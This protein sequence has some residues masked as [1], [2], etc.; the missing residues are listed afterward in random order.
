MKIISADSHFNEPPKFYDSLHKKYGDIVP[1]IEDEN[2]GSF[3]VSDGFKRPLGVMNQPGARLGKIKNNVSISDTKYIHDLNLRQAIVRKDGVSME[4]L[5]PS[6]AMLHIIRDENIRLQCFIKLNNYLSEL[7]QF[8]KGVLQVPNNPEDAIKII[9]RYNNTRFIMF[10]LYLPNSAY[11][12]GAWDSCFQL[13]QDKNI[14]ICFHAGSLRYKNP[15]QSRIF[16][17]YTHKTSILFFQG[18]ELLNDLL[19]GGV[20]QDYPGLKFIISELGVSWIPYWFHRIKTGLSIYGSLD[21]LNSQNIKK[22]LKRSFYFTTQFDFPTEDTL[23]IIGENNTLFGTDFPHVES[24]HGM[25]IELYEKMKKKHGHAYCS[26]IFYNNF[27]DL[28]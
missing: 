26:K 7:N 21:K 9:S 24:T 14:V 25:T 3:W 2:N 13:C 20:T 12:D 4:L 6:G 1:H 22:I 8:F 18:F 17:T 27:K 5:F 16:K 10:P 19:L 23:K 15:I 11:S 28:I